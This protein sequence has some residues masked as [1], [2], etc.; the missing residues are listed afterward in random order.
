MD[1]EGW[2]SA[3]AQVMGASASAMSHRHG[4]PIGATAPTGSRWPAAWD[5]SGRARCHHY[6]LGEGS[7]KK[8]NRP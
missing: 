3:L 1:C 7:N 5:A 6:G 8:A 2:K 4:K